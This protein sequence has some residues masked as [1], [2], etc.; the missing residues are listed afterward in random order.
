MFGKKQDIEMMKMLAVGELEQLLQEIQNSKKAILEVSTVEELI[1][2]KKKV[3]ELVNEAKEIS[4][5]IKGAEGKVYDSRSK[6]QKHVDELQNL[7]D[8]LIVEEKARI[9]EHDDITNKSGDIDTLLSSMENQVNSSVTSMNQIDQVLETIGDSVKEINVTAQSMK[10]Q[11]KTFVETAQN[12]A[13][14][15]TGI[16]AIAEQTN[17]L[18]LN[19]SIEAARAGEAGKGFAVVAEEI[20]KLSDGTKELLDN[21]TN[22]LGA[23]ESASLRSNQE[24]EATTTGI[25]QVEKKV[26]E[27]SIHVQQSKKS[28]MLFQEQISEVADFVVVLKQNL[29]AKESSNKNTHIDTVQDS[30]YLLTQIVEE[31]NLAAQEVAVSVEKQDEVAQKLQGLTKYKVLG[32]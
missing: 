15:I 3:N 23:L 13:S 14:N 17:L 12:V 6:I 20:R 16:S 21:M 8:T 5:S 27:I 19:A 2:I 32:K 11:V 25:E 30:I 22:L 28:T 1:S 18:A 24:V 10:N 7:K 26:D 29:K 4:Q 31:M 9:E